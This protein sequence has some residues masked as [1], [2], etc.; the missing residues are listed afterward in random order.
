MNIPKPEDCFHSPICKYTGDAMCSCECGHFEEYTKEK[1][2][3][4]EIKT[5]E[6]ILE[7][8]EFTYDELTDMDQEDIAEFDLPQ[9]KSKRIKHGFSRGLL[10]LETGKAIVFFEYFNDKV[11]KCH[12]VLRYNQEDGWEEQ[13]F[14]GTSKVD[15]RDVYDK[16]IGERRAL[17]TALDK[18]NRRISK[19]IQ[20]FVDSR[21]PMLNDLREGCWNKLLKIQEKNL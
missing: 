18:L 20:A 6:D 10:G 12:L 7:T 14:I 8:S 21:I 9:P 15:P 3:E 2:M 13:E 11:V 5:H 19:E 4:K 1:F 17:M 16:D